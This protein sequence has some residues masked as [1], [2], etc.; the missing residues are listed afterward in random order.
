MGSRDYLIPQTVAYDLFAVRLVPIEREVTCLQNAN[1]LSENHEM[2]VRN[3]ARQVPCATN[4][5]SRDAHTRKGTSSR[6]RPFPEPP[7]LQL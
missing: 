1:F 2:P 6:S 4:Q 7:P 3:K 5:R